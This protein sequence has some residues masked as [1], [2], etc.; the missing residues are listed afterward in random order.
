M[1][2]VIEPRRQF[3]HAKPVGPPKALR[4]AGL[5]LSWRRSI[6]RHLRHDLVAGHHEHE[7]V[8]HLRMHAVLP[9]IGRQT[10]HE[11][12][13]RFDDMTVGAEDE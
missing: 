1:I 4:I 12:G 5:L 8:L 11:Q 9:Q 7:A 10:L 2:H 13:R 6:Q 3:A